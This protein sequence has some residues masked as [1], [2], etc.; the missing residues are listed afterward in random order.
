MADSATH[1]KIERGETTPLRQSRNLD[2]LGVA[3]YLYKPYLLK[4]MSANLPAYFEFSIYGP[5]P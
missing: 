3:S 2:E 4:E 5:G 1:K